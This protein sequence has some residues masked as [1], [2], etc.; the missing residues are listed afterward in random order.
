MALDPERYFLKFSVDFFVSGLFSEAIASLLPLE[1]TPATFLDG[2][3]LRTLLCS[4]SA[5][6]FLM[7]DW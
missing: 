7:K 5:L 4:F 1:G 3:E 2:L 6:A